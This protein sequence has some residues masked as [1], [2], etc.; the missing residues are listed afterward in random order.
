MPSQIDLTPWKLT[1]GTGSHKYVGHF[2]ALIESNYNMK[3]FL[4]LH[5]FGSS[6]VRADG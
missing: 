4:S 1:L 3:I 5:R 6:V 2:D